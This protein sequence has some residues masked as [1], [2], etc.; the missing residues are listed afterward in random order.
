MTRQIVLTVSPVLYGRIELRAN[1]QRHDLHEWVLRAVIGELI[2]RQNEDE[3]CAHEALAA[4]SI[5]PVA[6]LPNERKPYVPHS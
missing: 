3:R 4:Q 1:E 2:N 5:S 6:R